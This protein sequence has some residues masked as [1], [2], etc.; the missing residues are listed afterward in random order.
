VRKIFVVSD[1][2]GEASPHLTR[3]NTLFMIISSKVVLMGDYLSTTSTK[4]SLGGR[5][6]CRMT[7]VRL[8]TL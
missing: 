4:I 3:S 8:W 1:R 5:G 2:D 6:L 7:C